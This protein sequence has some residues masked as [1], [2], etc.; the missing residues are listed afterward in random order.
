V[1]SAS[2]AID[3]GAA[4]DGDQPTSYADAVLDELAIYARALAPSEIQTLAS[5]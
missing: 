2:G 4:A 5:Q 3:V 1:T